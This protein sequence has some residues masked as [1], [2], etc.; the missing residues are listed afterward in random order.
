MQALSDFPQTFTHANPT[1]IQVTYTRICGHLRP[2]V[3]HKQNLK[4]TSTPE[5]TTMTFD[6]LSVT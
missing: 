5:T 2:E 6:K 3:K 1:K 4:P